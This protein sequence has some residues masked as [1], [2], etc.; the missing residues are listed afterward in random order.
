MYKYF[1]I[2]LVSLSS[3]IKKQE[4]VLIHELNDWEFQYED[5]WFSAQVPGNNFSDL[6][7][8]GIINDPFYGT[9]EDS[10]QWIPEREWIYQT[11]FYNTKYSNKSF[12]GINSGNYGFLMNKFSRKLTIKNLSKSKSLSI[13]PLEMTVIN[14][15][16]IIICLENGK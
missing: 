5:K 3:C 16:S 14:K 13:S 9:N 11:T 12:Y 2:L 6:L 15:H 1:L 10:I 8:H 4:L 7:N